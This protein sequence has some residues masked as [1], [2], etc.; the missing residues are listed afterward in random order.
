M[1]N[2]DSEG[3]DD[4]DDDAAAMAMFKSEEEAKEQL[5]VANVGEKGQYDLV[6]TLSESSWMSLWGIAALFCVFNAFLFWCH[7]RKHAN[8]NA[9]DEIDEMFDRA[10][11]I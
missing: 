2:E 3:E 7:Y 11:Q 1:G 8:G 6:L 10:E 5:E 4:D 9:M